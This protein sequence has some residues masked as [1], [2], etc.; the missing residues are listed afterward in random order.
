MIIENLL[1][2]VRKIDISDLENRYFEIVIRIDSD[3]HKTINYSSL[4]EEAKKIVARIESSDNGRRKK[5]FRKL[6]RT[7]Y[8][9]VLEIDYQSP[10]ENSRK[11]AVYKVQNPSRI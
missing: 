4:E 3:N 1:D 10:L 9:P 7:I 11:S 2:F 8:T 6:E 5:L